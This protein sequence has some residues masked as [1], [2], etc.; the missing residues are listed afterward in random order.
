MVSMMTITLPQ[1]LR[2]RLKQEDN[3]SGLIASLLMSHY[4]DCRSEKQIIADTKNKIAKA[5]EDI[6]REK[7]IAEAVKKRT[8]EMKQSRKKAGI[9]W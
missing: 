9:K 1:E 4:K 8:K 7:R 2:D 6:D 5:Q 3:Q